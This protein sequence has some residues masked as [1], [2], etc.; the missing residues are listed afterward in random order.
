MVISN[1]ETEEAEQID[2]NWCAGMQ[3]FTSAY[4]FHE[5]KST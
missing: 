1:D 2:E 4:F 5:Q 3:R